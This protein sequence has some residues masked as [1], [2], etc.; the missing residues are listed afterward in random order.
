MQC[1]NCK[2]WNWNKSHDVGICKIPWPNNNYPH[3]FKVCWFG[4]NWYAKYTNRNQGR[5]CKAWEEKPELDK[6]VK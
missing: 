5:T 2:W 3:W 1:G 6:V 4:I